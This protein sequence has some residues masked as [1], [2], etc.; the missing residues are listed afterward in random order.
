VQPSPRR[1]RSV[2][3]RRLEEA[4]RDSVAPSDPAERAAMI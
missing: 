1:H 2:T 3:R 4:G